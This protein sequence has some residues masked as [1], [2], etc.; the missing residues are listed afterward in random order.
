M[1]LKSIR[2][3]LA[4]VAAAL[5]LSS[6][7]HAQEKKP[8]NIKIILPDNLYKQAE[9]KVEGVSTK[10][11]GAERKFQTPPLEPNKEWKYKIEAV[12]EPNNYTKIFRVREITFKAG[13]DITVD[14]RKKDEKIPDDVHIRYVPTPED[15][16]EEMGKLAKITK[17]DIVYDCGC[18]NGML[19][20]TA[21]KKFGAKK[22]VG[23]DIDPVRVAEAKAAV[24]EDKLGD[25]IE[26]REGN[27]LKQDKKGIGEA[28]VIMTYMGN[29]LNILF[30]PIL[31]N[32]LKPGSR[33][34]SHRFI[35]GDWKPDKT[36]K[37]KGQ[38]GD[39][40]TLH[41]WTITGKEKDGVYEKADKVDD[42]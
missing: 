24:K 41:V 20:R 22:A 2:M 37:I 18:G 36:I 23:I 29:D 33:V 14:L 32:S 6:I 13:D 19:I 27:A 4:A 11:T 35:M 38:D 26:I 31:W 1:M 12:I 10:Q 25:K 28:T 15:I 40:Y 8:A 16:A 21:V 17:E 5:F 30:R 42:E 3:P 7:S 9:V 39:D 34:V